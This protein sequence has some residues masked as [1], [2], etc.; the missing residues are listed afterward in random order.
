MALI[1]WNSYATGSADGGDGN[2]DEVGGLVGFNNGGIDPG[3][4]FAT[5]TANGGAGNSDSVGGLVG[6][7]RGGIGVARISYATGTADGGG[8]DDSCGWLGR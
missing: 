7:N 6:R 3:N 2:S 1:A 5:G 4:S 8:G